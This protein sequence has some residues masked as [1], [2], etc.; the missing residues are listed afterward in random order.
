MPDSKLKEIKKRTF[1]YTSI[2]SITIPSNVEL[3]KSFAFE[4]CKY[5][6]YVDFADNSKLRIIETNAFSNTS[7][8]NICIPSN[9]RQISVKAFFQCIRL[10]IIEFDSNS[11]LFFL[12]TST[13]F[14]LDKNCVILAPHELVKV[15]KSNVVVLK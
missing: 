14:L 3:I 10:K 13:F 11:E 5:L 15:F 12:G 9:V 2:K 8:N 6:K 4:L 7:I 1:S